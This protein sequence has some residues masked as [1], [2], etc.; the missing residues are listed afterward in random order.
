MA[1]VVIS[2]VGAKSAACV[3]L[4]AAVAA[5]LGLASPSAGAVTEPRWRIVQVLSSCPG[6]IPLAVSA[7]GPGTA[8]SVG[9]ADA[10]GAGCPAGGIVAERWNGRRWSVAPPQ[11]AAA[12]PA[13]LSGVIAASSARNAWDFPLVEGATPPRNVAVNWNGASWTSWQLPGAMVVRQA[14]AFSPANA[15]V[16]GSGPR[17]QVNARFNGSAWQRTFL[18]GPPFG[19]SA[20]SASDMWAVGP[21][22]GT[23]GKPPSRQVIIAMH[24]TGKA[25]HKLAIPHALTSYRL[26]N[27]FNVAATSPQSLWW[28]FQIENA[29][30][31][32]E[33]GGRL[34]HWNGR[35][36]TSTAL[37]ASLDIAE[38]MQQ[39]G[40]GGI[41]LNAL[42]TTKGGLRSF[43]YHYRSGH[44]T[45]QHLPAPVGYN[46]TFVYQ[47]CWIPGTDQI[48][49]AGYA[50]SSISGALVGVIERYS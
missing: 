2:R 32:A 23:A 30:G 1:P 31:N 39:D 8:W 22:S 9:L 48:W 19:V 26:F 25:W 6:D 40:N 44:W 20:L 38:G 13:G 24:W 42:N 10:A 46:L 43:V 3:G 36:W 34:L 16:F 11:P 49:A 14:V 12:S 47:I 27:A 18:P 50:W 29:R 5:A 15:W 21:T 45:R 28:A 4:S 35:R 33:P 37:P 17:G 41:W 7:T